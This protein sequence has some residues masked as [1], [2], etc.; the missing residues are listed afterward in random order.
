[1]T[2]QPGD[3]VLYNGNQIVIFYGS[4]SWPYTRLGKIK[5]LSI[6]ELKNLLG[7]GNVELELK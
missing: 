5:G 4:N 3:I 6:E 1:M 7:N 2:T